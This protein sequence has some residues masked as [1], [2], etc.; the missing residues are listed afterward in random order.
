MRS[1][2]ACRDPV[3]FYA[4]H[5]AEFDAARGRALIERAWLDA[6]LAD[7]PAG[8][9]ILD[10]GC[11]AG[12]PMAAYLLAQGYR[13]TGV[14]ASAPLLALA[15]QRFPQARWV[16]AD[17][18]ELDLGECF[19]GI[20]A[21]DSLFHLDRT[22]QAN[23]I[24]TIGRHAAPSAALMFNS[25]GDRGESVGTMFGEPLFHASL[26]P[27][28]YRALLAAQ[29]FHVLRHVAQDQTCGGRT[30]WL[31]RRTKTEGRLS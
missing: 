21:W 5:A 31:A 4:D 6:F 16:Q 13:V 23:C 1:A 9:H 29:A 28:D 10:L 24:E 17:M 11:G 30:I 25:G 22:A 3:E 14:D 20:L 15:R 19:D 8:G 2:P 27:A 12:E 18:R 26:S 7:I